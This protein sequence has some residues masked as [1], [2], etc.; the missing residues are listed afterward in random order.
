VPYECRQPRRIARA[1]ILLTS[2][3]LL[4]AVAC[5]VIPVAASTGPRAW[6][7]GTVYFYDAGDLGRTVTT[8][9]ERWND[10]GARVRLVQV[11]AVEDAD[12]IFDVDDRR[13]RSACGS[14]CLGYTT[15]IGR[16]SGGQV[17]VL[18]ASELTGQPRPLS[19]W[20]AAHEFGHVLGLHH[21]DGRKCSL[22]SAHAFD[23]SCAP[24]LAAS[25]PTADQLACV[26]APTDVRDAAAMYGGRLRWDDTRCR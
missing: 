9:A 21:R 6:E 14:D 10:S 20:V 18:L 7:D 1:L 23:T 16:P 24:S 2:A 3:A 17:R 19:V 13:L 25:P 26:P 22:M 15:S 12:V 5:Y 11:A 4:V 8:A